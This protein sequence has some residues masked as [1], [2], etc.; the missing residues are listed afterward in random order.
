[1]STLKSCLLLALSSYVSLFSLQEGGFFGSFFGSKE[2]SDDE[3]EDGV[4]TIMVHGPI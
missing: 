1:M 3:I 2:D 4:K